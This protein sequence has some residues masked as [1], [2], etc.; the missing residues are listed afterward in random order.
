MRLLTKALKYN[1]YAIDTVLTTPST[2]IHYIIIVK[3][4]A[5]SVTMTQGIILC[6]M[7]HDSHY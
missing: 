2:N 3:R 4:F 7:S 1:F 5:G 6:L